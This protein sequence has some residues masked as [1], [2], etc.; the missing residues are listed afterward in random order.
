MK[1]IINYSGLFITG[2]DCGNRKRGKKQLNKGFSSINSK[3]LGD[4]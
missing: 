2:Q 1:G 3:T 4:C